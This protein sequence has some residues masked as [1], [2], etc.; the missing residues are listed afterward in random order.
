[1]CK[2]HEVWYHV[3]YITTKVGYASILMAMGIAKAA[4]V[5]SDLLS[6]AIQELE[7]IIIHDDCTLHTC[8][9]H[10]SQQGSILLP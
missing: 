2:F 3:L 10:Y 8:L 4:F 5:E 1:M 9:K 7:N 6:W